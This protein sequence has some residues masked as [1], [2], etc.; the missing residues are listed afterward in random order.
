MTG[1]PRSG[2]RQL[3]GNIA[4]LMTGK[5]AAGVISLAYLA[6]AA[7]MLGVGD[8]GVL[9]LVHG[10]ATL[11]GG[12]VAFSGWHGLVRYGA[13]ALHEDD[14][15]RLFGL[16]RLMAAIEIGGALLAIL[17]AIVLVP[18]VGPRLGWS[19][20]A[21]A[22]APLYSLAIFATVR[23]TPQGL[24][25]LADR[26]DLIGAHQVVM[27]VVRL[28]GAG[29]ALAIGG[30]L[31][32]F[33]IVWLVAALAEGLSMWIMAW[34]ATRDM[35]RAGRLAGPLGGVT[36]ANPGLVRFAVT[37]NGDI[38][39]RELAPRA[40]PLVIG[41][42]LG[43]IAAGLF[44]MAQKAGAILQQ[45]AQMLGQAAYPVIARLASQRSPELERTVWRSVSL[46]TL[47]AIPVAI[48]VSLFGREI[49]TLLGGK[50]FAAGVS[51]LILIVVARAIAV[52][53]PTLT[54]ALTALGRPGHS[55]MVNLATNLIFLA[56]LPLLLGRFEL[57]GAGWQMIAQ[58]VA[59]LAALGW[60]VHRALLA[61]TGNAPRRIDDG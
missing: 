30:G 37:T 43:P 10:Y 14:H 5:A 51:V 2:L 36:R 4:S 29:I 52:G 49:L 50:G 9:N 12:I 56:M 58:N 48:G 15:D 7:R 47:A 34:F 11:I 44:A 39:L 19:P 25:Q 1:A 60:L 13:Q 41:W 57:D 33:L 27:P 61:E 17:V 22:F 3:A 20:A 8:Y 45:P 24:L 23:A 54:A 35:R 16:V 6:I 18:F 55:I 31:R 26:F 32:T 53:L 42:V 28:L 59:A 38:T 46:A 21:I 40:I